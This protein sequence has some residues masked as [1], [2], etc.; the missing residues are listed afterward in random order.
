MQQTPQIRNNWTSHFKMNNG[1][2][3]IILK[4]DIML[5]KMQIQNITYQYYEAK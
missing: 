5:N 2:C 3:R 1:K 4:I